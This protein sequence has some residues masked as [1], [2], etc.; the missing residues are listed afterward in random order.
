[1]K[2]IHFKKIAV[3]LAAIGLMAGAGSANAVIATGTVTISGTA[4]VACTVSSPTLAFGAIPSGTV[5][6]VKPVSIDVNC[7]TATAWSLGTAGMANS[8]AVTVGADTTSNVAR[9][10]T[11]GGLAIGTANAQTGTGTGAIQTQNLQVR[12][13]SAGGGAGLV[14]TGAVTGALGVSLTY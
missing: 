8:Q 14:G 9:L 6:Q 4:A 13:G 2:M 11:L 10:E 5:S 1:M 12:I 7:P 3:A